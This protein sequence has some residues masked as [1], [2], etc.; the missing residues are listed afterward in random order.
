M[1]APFFG[2]GF[3]AFKILLDALTH[4][5]IDGTLFCGQVC[6]RDE[7]KTHK[8]LLSVERVLRANR[9]RPRSAHWADAEHFARSEM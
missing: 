7:G 5:V 2:S 6:G 9:E 4:V 1:S 3:E 8:T